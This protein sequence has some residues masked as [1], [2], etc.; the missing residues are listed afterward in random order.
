MILAATLLTAAIAQAQDGTGLIVAPPPAWVEPVE[1]TEWKKASP[2]NGFVD[3]LIDI[4]VN[5]ETEETF[6]RIVYTP[7]TVDAVQQ[8]STVTL[9]CDP[10]YSAP[11]LHSAIK[12]R[13]GI[14]ED[15]SGIKF[16]RVQREVDLEES[17]YLGIESWVAFLRDVAAGDVI[18]LSYT[19]RGFNPIFAGLYSSIIDMQGT[20]P[21]G[22]ASLRVRYPRDRKLS[23]KVVGGGSPGEITEEGSY[24]EFRIRRAAV[25]AI[26]YEDNLP[27][28]YQPASRVAISEFGSWADVA[29]WGSRLYEFEPAPAIAAK[30]AELVANEADPE[31]R[32]L[33][34]LSFV[35]DEVRYLGIEA[36]ENSHRPHDPAEV[37]GNRFG[38]CKDK[39]ALFCALAE[40]A[41]LRA[42]PALVSSWRSELVDEDL[43]S[44]ESFNHVI[45]RLEI[46]DRTF[47][48]DPTRSLQGGPLAERAIGDLRRALVLAP[49]TVGI[50]RLPEPR[51]ISRSLAER[52]TITDFTGSANLR[53]E[54]TYSSEAADGFRAFAN[55]KAEVD[56]RK[57]FAEYLLD[58]YDDVALIGDPKIRDDRI[59]NV[60]TVLVHARLPRAWTAE[61]NKSRFTVSPYF[62]LDTMTDPPSVLD[63]SQPYSLPYHEKVSHRQEIDFPEDWTVEDSSD[64]RGGNFF[65]LERSIRGKGRVVTIDTSF[66]IDADRV[67]PGAWRAYLADLKESR[68]DLGWTFTKNFDA[69]SSG[70]KK[71]GTNRIAMFIVGG[72]L[73]GASALSMGLDY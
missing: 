72:L 11:T 28:G 5:L 55:E 24:R 66:R 19:V 58:R 7:T 41:G 23:F 52:I 50:S 12:R 54:F 20:T 3:H 16:Q 2:P 44:P 32:A 33:A 38:D 13:E 25:P 30:A 48:V 47:F 49:G 14:A 68:T 4:Q 63:R 10:S 22:L 31:S 67:Q 70:S 42:R 62:V 65:T 60:L 53:A 43:P 36:G 64:S 71:G 73:F 37:L 17:M 8:G 39:A 1:W 40:A 27:H 21:I 29:A 18:E 46:G 69:A 45:A 61:G 51:P 15:Q 35:Q 6:F 26:R 56:I 59:T 9:S 34:I 57:E